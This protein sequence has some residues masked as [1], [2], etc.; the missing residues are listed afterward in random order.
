MTCRT[1]YAK[2]VD[3]ILHKTVAEG[4]EPVAVVARDPHDARGRVVRVELNPEADLFR[5]H[6][7]DDSIEQNLA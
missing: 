3:L 6:L 5:G 1:Y 4:I 2:D 7:G